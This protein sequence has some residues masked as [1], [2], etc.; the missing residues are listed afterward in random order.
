MSIK[1][2]KMGNS[3]GIHLP[4]ELTRALS[5]KKGSPVDIVHKDNTIIITPSKKKETLESLLKKVSSTNFH[6]LIELGDPIG[7]ELI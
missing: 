4:Q 1:I 3:L 5:L 6:E 7:K 2:Q